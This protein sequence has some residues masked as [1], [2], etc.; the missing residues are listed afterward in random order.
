MKTFRKVAENSADTFHAVPSFG[1]LILIGSPP[2][3]SPQ[4]GIL[5]FHRA[6]TKIEAALCM[7]IRF[8]SFGSLR[9]EALLHL[10]RREGVV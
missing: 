1:L 7:V 10:Q 3:A 6:H 9:V 8:T 2:H 5:S 4:K